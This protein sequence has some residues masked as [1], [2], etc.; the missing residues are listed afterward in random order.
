MIRYTLCHPISEIISGL[1]FALTCA[2]MYYLLAGSAYCHLCGFI[3]LRMHLLKIHVYNAVLRY[4]I[5]V[6]FMFYFT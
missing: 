5:D 4:I 2:F 3:W 6:R 1:L